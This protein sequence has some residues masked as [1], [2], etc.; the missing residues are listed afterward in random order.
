MTPYEM[1]HEA[2]RNRTEARVL[3]ESAQTLRAV[4]GSIRGLLSGIAG[5][6]RT[7]WQGPAATQFEQEAEI[8]SRNVDEQADEI[9]NE[10][11]AFEARAAHLQA[12]ANR[13][14]H[15]ASRVEGLQPATASTVSLPSGMF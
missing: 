13:L 3:E 1:R 6:S 2:S 7:V 9:A 8:Q 5:V 15:E 11:R 12:E 14:V 10:A 4:A